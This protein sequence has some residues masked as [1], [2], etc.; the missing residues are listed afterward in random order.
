[1]S[2]VQIK[3]GIYG[4]GYYNNVSWDGTDGDYHTLGFF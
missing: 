2:D 4:R 3:T 1:M